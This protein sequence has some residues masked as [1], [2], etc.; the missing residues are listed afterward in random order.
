MKSPKPSKDSSNSNAA[1][2][3]STLRIP[4]ASPCDHLDMIGDSLIEALGA[5]RW[6]TACGQRWHDTEV[7]IVNDEVA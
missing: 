6:C 2:A 7:V 4:Y 5:D 3:A 1:S